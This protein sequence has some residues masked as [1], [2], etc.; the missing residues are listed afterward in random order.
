MATLT[1]VPSVLQLRLLHKLRDRLSAEKPEV[2][3]YRFDTE[4]GVRKC[5]AVGLKNFIDLGSLYILPL[6]KRTSVILIDPQ[7][8]L[9]NSHDAIPMTAKESL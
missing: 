3:W 9:P 1:Y 6:H 7:A 4:P 2:R 8:T 5:T